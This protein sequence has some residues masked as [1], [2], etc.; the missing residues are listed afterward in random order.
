MTTGG[1]SAHLR[2][3]EPKIHINCSDDN[4]RCYGEQQRVMGPTPTKSQPIFMNDV[5]ATALCNNK[6]KE[7][8]SEICEA[9]T[10][11]VRLVDCAFRSVGPHVI[12]ELVGERREREQYFP[13]VNN[14]TPSL[15]RLY[16]ASKG[17]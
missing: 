12:I 6:K 4:S 13:R 15:P 14:A 11:R 2:E 8:I 17:G 5:T 1:R 16:N 7:A 9:L 3:H 10:S